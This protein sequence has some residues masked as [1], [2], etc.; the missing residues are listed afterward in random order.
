MNFSGFGQAVILVL[1]ELGG[2]GIMTIIF[3]I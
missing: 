1:M 3:L 2:I